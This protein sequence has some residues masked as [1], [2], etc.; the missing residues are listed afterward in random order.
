MTWIKEAEDTGRAQA[1]EEAA[2]EAAFKAEPVSQERVAAFLREH[3]EPVLPLVEDLRKAGY[4]VKRTGPGWTHHSY[5]GE[6]GSEEELS[7]F[8]LTRTVESP[9]WGMTDYSKWERQV[10]AIEFEVSK[11]RSDRNNP[12]LGTISLYPTLVNGQSHYA[13]VQYRATGAKEYPPKPHGVDDP[14]VTAGLRQAVQGWIAKAQTPV[15]R[16]QSN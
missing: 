15:G 8:T 3:E 16:K 10:F 2:R 1:A 7:G 12:L 11:D 13:G 14:D 6:P 5:R 9:G 4:K